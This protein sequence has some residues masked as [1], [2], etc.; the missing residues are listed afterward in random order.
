MAW[1]WAEIT[2]ATDPFDVDV[3]NGL[4]RAVHKRAAAT[5]LYNLDA[6]NPFGGVGVPYPTLTPGVVDATNGP[7]PLLADDLGSG[8]F[9]FMNVREMQ[10]WLYDVR[11]RYVNHLDHPDGPVGYHSGYATLSLPPTYIWRIYLL[12]QKLGY[13]VPAVYAA[14]EYGIAAWCFRRKCPR[15]IYKL[16]QTT[17]EDKE[18]TPGGGIGLPT[19]ASFVTGNLAQFFD[20]GG[21]GGGFGFYNYPGRYR[22]VYR[23][24]GT[25]WEPAPDG[26]AA[27]VLTSDATAGS[28]G[29]T[30][31]GFFRQ[32]DYYG[33]WLL[34][35]V[36]K[37]CDLLKWSFF[38]LDNRSIEN[39]GGVYDA[40]TTDQSDEREFGS[41]TFYD[42]RSAAWAAAEANYAGKPWE[43]FT[44][45]SG[46][47]IYWFEYNSPPAAGH[48]AQAAG[49]IVKWQWV[50]RTYDNLARTV[51]VYIN[52]LDVSIAGGGGSFWNGGLG[53]PKDEWAY[54]GENALPAG[55]HQLKYYDGP[56]HLPVVEWPAGAEGVAHNGV[57]FSGS[58]TLSSIG[59]AKWTFD[60]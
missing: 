12:C 42:G 8:R 24:N 28:N 3:I 39:F 14:T 1:T 27:D 56:A 11:G 32:G 13:Y 20:N 48:Y 41:L 15:R 52:L 18:W 60:D 45:L 57:G 53:Y 58:F 43:L 19:S 40:T 21:V 22:G 16:D 51:V 5:G 10:R 6:G 38:G 31:A 4:L 36:R 50:S 35:D 2:A 25:A 54:V 29:W 7:D 23:F 47:A 46:S 9:K 34:E 30:P 55:S 44:G 17:T 26:A 37:V 59:V 33:W 49:S